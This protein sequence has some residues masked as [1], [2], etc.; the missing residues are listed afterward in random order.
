LDYSYDFA[1]YV[2]TVDMRLRMDTDF[3]SKVKRYRT[4]WTITDFM[5]TQGMV[6]AEGERLC[7][8]CLNLPFEETKALC[9]GC[10]P[11]YVEEK[12]DSRWLLLLVEQWNKLTAKAE[13]AA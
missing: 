7:D 13:G 11:D 5:T 2:A 4:V 6:L 10:I 12:V 1:I 8:R 9:M 3:A